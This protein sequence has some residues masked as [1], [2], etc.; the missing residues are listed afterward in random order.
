MSLDGIFNEYK[1]WIFQPNS[2]IACEGVENRNFT[3]LSAD[4]FSN[5]NNKVGSDNSRFLKAKPKFNLISELIGAEVDPFSTTIGTH[6]DFKHLENTDKT[7]NHYITSVFIDIKGSTKLI[8]KDDLSLMQVMMVKKRFMETVI[9]IFTGFDS[10]IHRLQGDGVFAFFGHKGLPKSQSIVNALNATSL[11]QL[12]FEKIVNK[13]LKGKNLPEIKL[14]IGIDFGYDKDV[15]WAN[16]GLYNINEVTTTSLHTDL[17]AKLQNKAP[18]NGIMI[19]SNIKEHLDIPEK[20]IDIP[21]I[22]GKEEEFIFDSYGYKYKM[23]IFKWEKYFNDFLYNPFKHDRTF[24]L[25]KEIKYKCKYKLP[26][27]DE[28]NELLSHIKVLPKGSDL[29]FEITSIPPNFKNLS[30]KWEVEN[31]GQE[32]Y[33]DNSL[34]FEMNRYSNKLYCKQ[35]TKYKGFHFM[36]LTVKHQGRTILYDRF[37]VHVNND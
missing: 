22:L 21:Q 18:T 15:L 26:G 23:W 37:G 24:K 5:L 12:F 25:G 20:Y 14:R 34:N 2:Q 32:A 3:A 10:H 35:T 33:Q 29:L 6:P 11:T 36:K 4:G 13:E 30:I 7:E 1:E 31:Y 16:Y 9:D 19:G 17:A 8:K 27:K 28:Y